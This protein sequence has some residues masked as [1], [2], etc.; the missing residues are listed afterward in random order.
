MYSD[1]KFFKKCATAIRFYF[2]LCTAFQLV[3]EHNKSTVTIFVVDNDKV[4][5]ALLVFHYVMGVAIKFSEDKTIKG[6]EEFK[7]SELGKW[8]RSR[9]SLASRSS[10]Y[11]VASQTLTLVAD[12]V[13]NDTKSVEPTGSHPL[14]YTIAKAW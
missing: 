12:F 4:G 9:D 1:C 7:K 6:A 8:R 11:A 10:R 14:P 5:I 2:L 3:S 13:S